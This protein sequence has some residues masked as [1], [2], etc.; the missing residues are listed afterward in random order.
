MLRLIE[1]FVVIFLFKKRRGVLSI[2]KL[3][4]LILDVNSFGLKRT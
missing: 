3:C 2:S 4:D 1:L